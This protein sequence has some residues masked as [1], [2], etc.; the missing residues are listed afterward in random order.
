M[1]RAV[2]GPPDPDDEHGDCP[3]GVC[4]G[5]GWIL[6]ED[7]TA[8][9]CDCREQ[10]IGRALSRGMGTGIPK[11]FRGVS[12]DRKPICDLDPG[13]LRHV[14]RFTEGLDERIEAGDG[15]WFFGDVGTGKSSLAML[16]ASRALDGG[17]SVAVYSVPQL[18]SQLRGSFDSDSQESFVSLFR[19]LCAVDLL[20]LD[21]LGAERQTAWVL[22][23]L[24]SIVNERWQDGRAIVVT[25][26][27]P[28]RSARRPLDQLREQA[29]EL[30]ARG[31]SSA[32]ARDLIPVVE[33]LEAVTRE[34]ARLDANP[35]GDHL[36]ALREQVGERTVSRLIE[37]CDEPIPIM[38]ADLRLIAGH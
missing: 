32:S 16:V 14:R 7:G 27:V 35:H 21:D 19:R 5:N 36:Q 25:S 18:L 31:E 20:V 11:R 13:V 26:N 17:R 29:K 9:P 12:Y 34:L 33:R 23:Q 38:G 22:E 30:R 1:L 28:K 6:R 24:Y 8:V 15:L 3:L 10:R 4:E 2:P 37:I